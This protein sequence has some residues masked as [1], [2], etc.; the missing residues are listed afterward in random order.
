MKKY[1]AIIAVTA[2]III[3]GRPNAFGQTNQIVEIPKY[4]WE[5]TL[6]AGLTLT[7]GNSDTLLTSVALKTHKK[8]PENE[9]MFGADG[10]Y[11]KDNGV[12]NNNS[13]H[14][15]AQYNHLFS[16]RFFGYVIAEGL[17]DGIADLNYR[18]TVGPGAGYYLLKETN[19]TL[20]VEAGVSMVTEE[21][22]TNTTTYGSLRLAERFE[23]K[24][25][26]SARVW[27][28]AELLPQVNKLQNF[29]VNAEVGAE[30]A[31]SKNFSLSVVLQDNF[32]DQPA[33][34]RKNN[35]MKLISGIT[36]KF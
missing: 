21:L 10:T 19:T 16:E 14:G 4:P 6:T 8:T 36:Y 3:T 11:G 2:A 25:S 5:S 9:F 31:L 32:V 34:G 23:H 26:D 28:K 27:E 33:A 35:D 22:G 29:L 30:A 18:I 20:A 7:E 12:E 15:V 13:L 24:F 1:T 17:H